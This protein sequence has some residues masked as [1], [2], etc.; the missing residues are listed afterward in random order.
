[1]SSINV[2]ILTEGQLNYHLES[3][4]SRTSG[5]V[6]QKR[7]RLRRF[8]D[9]ENQENRRNR[10]VAERKAVPYTE[11]DTQAAHMLCAMRNLKL[12][13]DIIEVVRHNISLTSR[14][15]EL[16][17]KVADLECADIPDLTPIEFQDSNPPW[18]FENLSTN[19]TLDTTIPIMR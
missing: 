4:H 15:L 8:L 5:T 1:M 19:Y 16:E 11:A 9:M 6:T 14:V 10:S 13:G 3:R 18:N 12:T 17:R 7:E 2:N